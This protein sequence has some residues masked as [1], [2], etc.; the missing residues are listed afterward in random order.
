MMKSNPDHIL[1]V[2]DLNRRARQLLEIQFSMV[3]VRGEI[4]NLSTPSSGHSYFTLK[5]NKA[6]IRCAMFKG[7]NSLLRFKPE[8]GM[9]I[10][11]RG[12]VSLY[13]GRGDYQL[14][15]ENMSVDGAGNLQIAFEQLKQKLA[16]ERLFDEEFKQA[17]PAFPQHIGVITSPT[18]AVIRDILSVLK[19]RFPAIRVSIFPVP[20]Q[21]EYAAPAIVHALALANQQAD[22]DT[23]ILARGGGSLEDLWAFNEEAVVRAVF[24]SEIPVVSAVGHETDF[25]LC[26]FVADVR[27]PTPSVAAELQHCSPTIYAN[28]PHSRNVALQRNACTY[29]T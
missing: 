4:S 16:D 3:W 5:D 7:N 6:Q 24:A 13:E 18:G 11:A 2:T 19:R 9:Q 26:D 12:R 8:H 28:S 23:L 15:I 17:L 14:I 20:V 29:C 10:I 22:I 27:A 25:T 1:S 21:G